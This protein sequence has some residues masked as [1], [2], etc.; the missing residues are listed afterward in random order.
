MESKQSTRKN[1]GLEPT[2]DF[3][4]SYANHVFLEA[5][6][7][8]LK[9]IFGQLDQSVE[10]L[11]VAQHTAVTLPWAQ[12]KILSH[13]LRVQLV[14]HEMT[15]GKISLPKNILP[16]EVE[17]PTEKMLKEEPHAQRMYEEFKKLRDELLANS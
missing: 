4:T 13:L 6:F 2:D 5:S 15:N 3:V 17:P 7:W 10:P 11:A 1:I 16:S 14:A 12:A 8:D 9:L